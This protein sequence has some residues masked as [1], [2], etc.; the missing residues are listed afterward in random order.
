MQYFHTCA[1]WI[2]TE[3]VENVDYQ[4]FHHEISTI[5]DQGYRMRCDDD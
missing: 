2:R 3:A 5:H 4:C 1:H